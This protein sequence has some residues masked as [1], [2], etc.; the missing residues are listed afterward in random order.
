MDIKGTRLGTSSRRH[1]PA[2][3]GGGGATASQDW[4]ERSRAAPR[5]SPASTRAH[6]HRLGSR[7]E[8]RGTAGLECLG[9]EA[10]WPTRS[11]WDGTGWRHGEAGSQAGPGRGLR[12]HRKWVLSP[13]QKRAGIPG[14]RIRV[15]VIHSSGK[16]ARIRQQF[17]R[18]PP[19][20]RPSLRLSH[21]GPS[22]RQGRP[23]T[24]CQA[25]TRTALP[26]PGPT[27]V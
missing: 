27:L 1:E 14:W 24:S 22:I 3:P 20:R 9:I 26:G 10:L 12:K 19:L 16:E 7:L 21:C 18:P 15:A 2:A 23:G 13:H 4:T 17:S 25:W 8:R 11:D 6:S 5:R